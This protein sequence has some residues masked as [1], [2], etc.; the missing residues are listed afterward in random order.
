MTP[1]SFDFERHR[2]HLL[3]VAYR[4]FGS[5]ADAEDAVQEA[6][7]RWDATLRDGAELD[8]PLA[9]LTTVTAR[10]CLDQLRSARVR[11]EAYVGQWL[12]EPVV[13]KLPGPGAGTDRVSDPAELVTQTDQVS[14]ALLVVLERLSPEQRVAFVLHDVFAVPFDEIATLLATSPA[15]ARQLASRARRAVA[16]PA[17]PR[18]TADLAEQRRVVTAFVTAAQAGDIDGLV[19]VLAPDAVAIGDGGGVIPAAARPVVGALPV[20]RFLAGLF[21]RYYAD[22]DAESVLINGGLGFVAE[23]QISGARARV[24]MSFAIAD[25]RVTGVFNQLNPAKLSRVP[26]PRP[27][28]G[29]QLPDWR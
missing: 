15:A 20:A 18:H 25:G 4:I 2:Q 9:W 21:R 8:N 13:T 12:P 27:G 5:W 17:T 3:G 24:T 1:A 10:I 14:Y 22:V 28:A 16:A 6:W 29:W 11:R 23:T 7:L 26:A 19:A